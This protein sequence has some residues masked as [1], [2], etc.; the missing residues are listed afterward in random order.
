MGGKT[1][2]VAIL[3]LVVGSTAVLGLENAPPPPS[4]SECLPLDGYKHRLARFDA[5]MSELERVMPFM[6]VINSK[7]A[8]PSVLCKL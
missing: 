6:M 8:F 5:K 1:R 7:Y 4:G 2:F 3:I